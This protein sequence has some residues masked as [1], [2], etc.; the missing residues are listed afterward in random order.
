MSNITPNGLILPE[1]KRGIELNESS[2][3]LVW[4]VLRRIH[5]PQATPRDALN[6]INYIIKEN[7]EFGRGMPGERASQDMRTKDNWRKKPD[8]GTWN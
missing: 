1:N 8:E 7:N 6:L 4:K 2:V 3:W 5:D